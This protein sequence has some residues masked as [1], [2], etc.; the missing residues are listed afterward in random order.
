V[1]WSA[2]RRRMNEIG[3]PPCAWA[4]YDDVAEPY[5]RFQESNGYARLAR[6]LVTSLNLTAGASLLDV[7]CG[8]GAA[9]A[10]A[11]NTVGARGLVV[12]LDISLAMLRRA[13]ASGGTHFLAGIVPG[14]PFRD[15]CFDAVAASLVLSHVQLYEVALH[16]MVRVV[17]LGG[18]IGVTAGARGQNSNLAYRVWEE[19]AESF[20]GR[21]ALRD[22]ARQVVPC[23]VWLTDPVNFQ[24]AL[25][26]VGLEGVEVL[27]R[28]YP[29]AMSTHDYLSMLDLFAYGRFLR[30]HLETVR[31][32]EFRETV[33]AKLA[34][35]ALARVE[36]TSRYHVG[37]GTTRR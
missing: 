9:T 10:A 2:P 35:H 6:D 18:R 7:G 23:E 15:C 27:Q 37:L 24:T 3:R 31:W 11:R 29:V 19:T 33:A 34:A 26:S 16:D 21:G 20:V 4:R 14:L 32:Q 25:E 22:A 36:Y 30:Q 17:K 1:L 5:D 28:E 12:G 8:S 13:S